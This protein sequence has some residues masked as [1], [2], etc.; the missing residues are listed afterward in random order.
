MREARYD[1]KAKSGGWTHHPSHFTEPQA[2]MVSFT[3]KA[4]RNGTPLGG[5]NIQAHV[6]SV[7]ARRAAPADAAIRLASGWWVSFRNQF[8]DAPE[9]ATKIITSVEPELT[10]ITDAL[11]QARG[12]EM[13]AAK[14]RLWAT[15]FEGSGPDFWR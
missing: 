1:L 15:T 12:A 4:L 2:R 13:V 9:V 10:E 8:A 5:H 3:L 7:T 14:D 6:E 11:E